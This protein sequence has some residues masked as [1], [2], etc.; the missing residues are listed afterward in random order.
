[1]K[2]KKKVGHVRPSWDEY[3][4]KVMEAVAKRATCSRGLSG[5]VI[6][7]DKQILTTGYVGS[8]PRMPHCDDVGHEMHKVVND[9]GTTSEHC[10]RTIHAEQ[11]A[12]M[13]ACRRGVAVEG[14]TLYCQMTPCYTCAKL[15]VAAGIKRVVAFNDYQRGQKSKKLFKKAGVRYELVNDEIE[16]Y[17]AKT[18]G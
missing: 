8:P 12:L 16:I 14:A 5:C 13:Q 15:I 4:F 11:N 1:M 3:F 9:D 2:K 17:P 10:I 7:K 18:R 6:A